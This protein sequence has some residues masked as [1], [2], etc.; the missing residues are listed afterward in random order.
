MKPSKEKN[1]F[2]IILFWSL[3]SISKIQDYKLKSSK[4]KEAIARLKKV[5]LITYNNEVLKFE[6]I[7][8]DSG[9]FFGLVE[10]KGKMKKILLN[11]NAIKTIILL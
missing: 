3:P 7:G 9:R 4:L 1:K 8:I 11:I 5:E 2:E 10:F 6:N